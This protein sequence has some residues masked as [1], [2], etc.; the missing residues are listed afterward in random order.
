MEQRPQE[1]KDSPGAPNCRD[2]GGDV[3]Y[4]FKQLGVR[5]AKHVEAYKPS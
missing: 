4:F 5:A 3:I 2:V 1:E